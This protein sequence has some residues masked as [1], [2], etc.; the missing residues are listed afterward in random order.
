[1][2]L[3]QVKSEMWSYYD[4]RTGP[5]WKKR[6]SRVWNLTL[7]M[8]GRPNKPILAAKAAETHGLLDF[9]VGLLQKYEVQLSAI[10]R[11][12]AL[13][14]QLLLASGKAAQKFNTLLADNTR[15]LSA[16][17][18]DSMMS[19]YRHFAVMYDRAGGHLTPKH[20]IMLHMIQRAGWHGNPRYYMTYR[21][22]S[23]NGVV[24]RI[25]A[26]CHRRSWDVNVHRK[27]N[28]LLAAF[29][30]EACMQMH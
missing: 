16:E 4:N 20:H 18:I 9:A 21:D 7:K 3:L 8:L 23:L 10:S 25:A 17:V 30:E 6:G 5:E 22:E 19:S 14:T 1:M 11:D 26:S 24:A 29:G 15:D 13:T 2:G 28:H 12:F 27:L